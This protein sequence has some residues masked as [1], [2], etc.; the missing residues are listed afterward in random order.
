M[1]ILT[2]QEGNRAVLHGAPAVAKI[3]LVVVWL[4][5]SVRRNLWPAHGSKAQIQGI[6]GCTLHN[7]GS[8]LFEITLYALQQF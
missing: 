8:K 7:C 3:G 4:W 2:V 1:F 5:G 6:T